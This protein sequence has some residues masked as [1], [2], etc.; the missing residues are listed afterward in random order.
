MLCGP[1]HARH[2]SPIS[3]K[4][5]GL[6]ALVVG[7]THAVRPS[8]VHLHRACREEPEADVCQYNGT[9]R[10]FVT[11]SGTLPAARICLHPP[12]QDRLISKGILTHGQWASVSNEQTRK[13]VIGKMLESLKAQPGA[14]FVDLGANIGTFSLQLLA[15]GFRGIL[16]EA[17]PPNVR[18]LQRSL[19]VNG[20]E[21]QAT[22]FAPLA[23]TN[24]SSTSAICMAL[25]DAGNSGTPTVTPTVDGVAERA[26]GSCRDGTMPVSTT[27]VDAIID[28]PAHS[29]AAL[30]MDVEKSELEVLRG[31]S[32]FLRQ[33]RPRDV[34]IEDLHQ[35]RVVKMLTSAGYAVG[36]QVGAFDFHLI[37]RDDARDA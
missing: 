27:S 18:L 22:L 12:E 20:F 34:F 31:A 16:V 3:Q 29:V 11:S 7:G 10:S 32:L 17:F 36:R 28:C 24:G 35:G 14:V 4:T 19:C 30:K 21:S 33:C 5:V 13:H 15:A 37:A 6:L 23:L 9:L 25:L 2:P 26:R 8:A 1:R